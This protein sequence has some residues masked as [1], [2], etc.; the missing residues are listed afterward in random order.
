MRANTLITN[1][2]RADVGRTNLVRVLWVAIAMAALLVATQAPVQA[3]TR[4]IAIGPN[5]RAV[6]RTT[7]R[8]TI[9]E[10]LI[11]RGVA[12]A[13]A[14]DTW[15]G[16]GYTEHL[17]RYTVA[18][19]VQWELAATQLPTGAEVL[20]TTGDW[21]DATGA[22]ATGAALDQGTRAN[23][24]EALVRVRVPDGTPTGWAQALRLELRR[25]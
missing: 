22:T 12:P 25:R 2:P 19:N 11:I 15:Q 21:M 1:R 17:L 24:A 14:D 10:I 8:Y 6:V 4:A 5:A 7:A 20:T 3:Q 23:A 16:T 9:P 13:T 18:A